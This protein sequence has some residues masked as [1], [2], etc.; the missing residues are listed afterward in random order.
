MQPLLVLVA[1]SSGHTLRA[2]Q[3]FGAGNLQA[4]SLILQRALL[5]SC[6]LSPLVWAA[7]TQ[8]PVCLPLLGAR[9]GRPVLAARAAQSPGARLHAMRRCSLR[10]LGAR[11]ILAHAAVRVRLATCSGVGRDT[12]VAPRCYAACG[13]RLRTLQHGGKPALQACVRGSSAARRARPNPNPIPISAGQDA[14]ISAAA[15][16][17]VQ[18]CAPSLL[19]N[20]VSTCIRNHLL[21]QLDVWRPPVR[22]P[23][24][25]RRCCRYCSAI[26]CVHGW[27]C[28]RTSSRRE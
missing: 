10:R 6:G 3:A 16:R 19:F 27:L 15:S 14:G 1:Q 26:A 2:A 9:L 28:P 18:I 21:A 25:P 24:P 4:M 23:R 5:L 11:G 7:W 8:L 17:Y 20:A 13:R 22:L 12:V